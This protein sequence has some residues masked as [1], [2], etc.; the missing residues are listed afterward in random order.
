MEVAATGVIGKPVYNASAVRVGEVKDLVVNPST[1][2]AFIVIASGKEEK[3]VPLSRAVVGEIVLL[4]EQGLRKCPSCGF[5]RVPV[6]ANY[7][8]RCGSPMPHPFPEAHG[9]EPRSS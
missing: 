7:C 6:D 9:S 2:E 3:R 5:E 4:L 8:P 1:G